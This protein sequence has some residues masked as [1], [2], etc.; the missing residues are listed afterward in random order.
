[1]SVL[2]DAVFDCSSVSSDLASISTADFPGVDFSKANWMPAVALY[3]TIDCSGIFALHQA[4][5]ARVPPLISFMTGQD[6]CASSKAALDIGIPFGSIFLVCAAEIELQQSSPS[7]PTGID[8]GEPSP[9]GIDGGSPSTTG[10]DGG[11]PSTTGTDEVPGSLP[12]G[13]AISPAST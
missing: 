3:P 7:S 9:T 1:M 12:S 13:A 8:G 10:T 11:A 2:S 6:T 5:D 4:P